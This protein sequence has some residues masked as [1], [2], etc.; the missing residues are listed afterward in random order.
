[1]YTRVSRRTTLVLCEAPAAI[2]LDVDMPRGG[3]RLIHEAVVSIEGVRSINL[4]G[5]GVE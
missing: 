1:M 5:F 3:D 4:Q 2:V